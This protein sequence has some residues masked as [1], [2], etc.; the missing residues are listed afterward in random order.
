MKLWDTGHAIRQAFIE[1]CDLGFDVCGD[2]LENVDC[3]FG[4]CFL[5]H[6]IKEQ[7]DDLGR[8]N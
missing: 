4:I 5:S 3:L 6:G 1:V 8:L 2:D 7:A